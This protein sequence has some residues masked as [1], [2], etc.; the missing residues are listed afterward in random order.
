[1]NPKLFRAS[2]QS[3]GVEV[4][5]VAFDESGLEVTL[6]LR[7]QKPVAYTAF[8]LAAIFEEHFEEFQMKTLGP[9]TWSITGTLK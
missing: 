8:D 7:D 4:P 5:M 9:R 1:M 6:T 2:L 3:N